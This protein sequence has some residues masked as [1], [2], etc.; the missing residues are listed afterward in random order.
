MS[1]LGIP[2]NQHRDWYENGSQPNHR[3][4]KGVSPDLPSNANGGNE[5]NRFIL[6]N[7]SALRDISPV[8]AA[9]LA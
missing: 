3:E 5:V 6:E 9:Y 1:S 2:F 4:G 7:V 8:D